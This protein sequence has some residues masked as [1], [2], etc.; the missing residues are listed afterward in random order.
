MY[1]V[2]N[3]GDD[4]FIEYITQEDFD[5]EGKFEFETY[6]SDFIDGGYGDYNIYYHYI[7]RDKSGS[8]KTNPHTKEGYDL[9][10]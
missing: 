3:D 8:I 9:V 4:I 2:F 1:D 5:N 6:L 7:V 10:G